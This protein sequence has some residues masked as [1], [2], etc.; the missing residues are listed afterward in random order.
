M[1]EPEAELGK[2][3]LDELSSARE[4]AAEGSPVFVMHLMNAK[5][6][7]RRAGMDV[8]AQAAEIER[9]GY[10]NNARVCLGLARERAEAKDSGYGIL[11]RSARM[12]AREA[13]MDISREAAEIIALYQDGRQAGKNA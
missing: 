11:L 8:S 10:T 6:L 9:T 2:I 5:D 12:Y 3:V 1:T 13:G 7:A 4:K